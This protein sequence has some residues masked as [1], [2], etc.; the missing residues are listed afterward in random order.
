MADPIPAQKG[1]YKV[2]VEAGRKYF[3]CACGRSQKQPFC[4]GSHKGTGLN[5]VPFSAEQSKDL[6]F[7]GCKATSKQPFCDGTHAKL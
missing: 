2:S 3:W 1:P 4:D 5:P 7:C 6:W